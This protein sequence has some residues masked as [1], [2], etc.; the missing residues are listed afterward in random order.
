MLNFKFLLE[1]LLNRVDLSEKESEE[2]FHLTLEGHLEE[3]HIAAWLIAARMKV[4]SSSELSAFAK[5]MY[6][7]AKK[8]SL[9]FDVID[10]CGTGG[11]SAH[12]INISTLSAISLASLKIPVAKHGNKAISSK[13]GSADLLGHLGYPLNESP[14]QTEQRIKNEY[15]GFMFA[16]LYHTAMQNVAGVRKKLQ[17]R[18]IFNILGPLTNPAGAKIHLLG[19]YSKN[20]LD[21]M[22]KSLYNLGVKNAMVVCSEDKIDEINPIQNT[23]FRLLRDSIITQGNILPFPGLDIRSLNEVKALNQ[24]DAFQKAENILE[25]KFRPGI[26]CIALNAAAV[27]YLWDISKNKINTEINEYL[28]SKVPELIEHISSGALMNVINKWNT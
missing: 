18:T 21:I 7:K 5:V 13:C 19:V 25:G 17:V 9:D 12:L 23:E 4:E 8:V 10:T 20:L 14:V 3:C 26:E 1:K 15:F 24:K 22:S 11:D 2:L 27:Y 28:R 6:Q 16:P